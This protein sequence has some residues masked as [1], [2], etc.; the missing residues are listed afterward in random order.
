MQ[1]NLDS[2][3]T[4][5]QL[6]NLYGNLGQPDQALDAINQ[7]LTIAPDWMPALINQASVYTSVGDEDSA[8]A[9]LSRAIAANP[10][11]GDPYYAQGL[12]Q[13]RT[14]ERDA[15]LVNLE[16]AATLSDDNPH[17]SYVYGVA[18]YESGETLSGANR[19]SNT[20]AANPTLIYIGLA[21][22]SY[23]IQLGLLDQARETAESL[24]LQAP[25]N[26]QVLQ[27]IQY[28]QQSP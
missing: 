10:D 12:S 9:S 25:N 23:Q 20:Y 17:Y 3:G 16:R 13:I 15:A 21:A 6:S 19:I 14:G 24:N 1:S 7:A 22:A 8:R 28:L 26:D 18:L 27:I 5:L 11:Q 4:A 2:P